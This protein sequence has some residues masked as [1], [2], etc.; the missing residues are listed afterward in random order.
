MWGPLLAWLQGP[1]LAAPHPSPALQ[2]LTDYSPHLP[3][4]CPC[5]GREHEAR[6]LL[7]FTLTAS[8][9]ALMFLVRKLGRVLG[10]MERMSVSEAAML[11]QVRLQGGGWVWCP[12]E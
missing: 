6:T 11:K 1:S 4:P 8:C 7:S 12:Q 9:V 5:L 3:M 10:Q 2:P